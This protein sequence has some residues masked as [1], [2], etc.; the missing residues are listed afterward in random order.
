MGLALNRNFLTLEML[1]GFMKKTGQKKTRLRE[2]LILALLLKLTTFLIIYLASHL[3]PFCYE[4]YANGLSNLAVR[5]WS[6]WLSFGTWDARH[7]TYLV[8]LGYRD[9][10]PSAAFYPL[11]PWLTFI[12]T[13]FGPNALLAGYIVSN[14]ASVAAIILFYKLVANWW[15]D[16]VAFYAS[17]LLML[18]PTGFYLNLMYSESLFLAL[19][20]AVFYLWDKKRPLLAALG[21]FFA[22]L[23]RPLGVLLI[24]PLLSELPRLLLTKYRK[25][26]LLLAPLFIALGAL[27]GFSFYLLFMAF[28]TGSPWT[29]FAAQEFFLAKNNLLNLFHPWQWLQANFLNIDLELHG[30]INS[31]IDRIVFGL[32]L[33]SL[34]F[35]YRLKQPRLFWYSVVMG[36]V[37]ALSGI[38]MAYTRYVLM[39]FPIFIVLA[40]WNRRNIL[41][42]ALPSYALQIL[43]LI[44]HALNFWVA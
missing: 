25:D 34:Y 10:V 8:E 11:L 43:L 5:P 20:L 31:I 30:F 38:M 2:L 9:F 32:Y 15:D 44:M 19:V 7:Y 28:S 13:W 39:V 41:Y 17:L 22:S 35:I 6:S 29:G 24:I 33:I 1:S 37:P 40:L 23:A 14:A 36:V 27:A 3:L 4:C 12:V 18:F 21:A 42:I 16:E 26:T